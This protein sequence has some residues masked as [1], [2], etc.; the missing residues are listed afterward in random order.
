MTGRDLW[1][2]RLALEHLMATSTRHE[3]WIHDIRAA[4]AKLP[5]AHE[6]GGSACACV[7][8]GSDESRS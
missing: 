8:P 1:V 5:E 2:T 7:A 4:L 3:H 6:P